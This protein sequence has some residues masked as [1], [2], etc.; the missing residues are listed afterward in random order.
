MTIQ[1]LFCAALDVPDVDRESF[2]AKSAGTN[3]RLA[4][5]VMD[6]LA[7]TDDGEDDSQFSAPPEVQAICRSLLEEFDRA[8]TIPARLGHY[9]IDRLL[10][11]GGMGEVY[12][13]HDEKLGRRVAIKRLAPFGQVEL[14]DRFRKEWAAV[15]Q[16]DSPYI[17]RGYA[18][19][20][21]AGADHL[22]MEY[23]DGEDLQQVVDEHG[24]MPP[25]TACECVHQAARGLAVAH[26]H[27][28]VHRDVKPA[29]LM[30]GL[31]GRVK[32]LDFGIAL[33]RTEGVDA[34]VRTEA[35]GTPDYAP[36]E[37][38]AG[39]RPLIGPE[40]DVYAL[41]CTLYFLLTGRP[42]FEDAIG[43]LH[44]ENAHRLA[45]PPSLPTRV[46]DW[47]PE[48]TRDLDLLIQ[49][50]LA[51]RP[52]D[53]LPSAD[54]V[55]RALERI[56]RSATKSAKSFYTRGGMAFLLVAAFVAPTLG[57]RIM[58]I[59]MSSPT[60]L[61]DWLGASAD[62]I[63]V[64]GFL[65]GVISLGLGVFQRRSGAVWPYFLVVIGF[66]LMFCVGWFARDRIDRTVLVE[67]LGEA[68][69]D[70]PYLSQAERYVAITN[71]LRAVPADVRADIR[72]ADLSHL[73]GDE[74]ARAI[75][76][77]EALAEGFRSAGHNVRFVAVQNAPSILRIDL[78]A[79]DTH[80]T[81]FWDR[82]VRSY[83][84]RLDRTRARD[85]ELAAAAAQAEHLVGD[86]IVV[87]Q[88]DWL[89][90][91]FA[92]L[93]AEK[94]DGLGLPNYAHRSLDIYANDYRNGSIDMQGVVRELGL[95]DGSTLKALLRR[96]SNVWLDT[97]RPVVTGGRV[98][99][100]AW[101]SPHGLVVSPYQ[102]LSGKLGLGDAI[103]SD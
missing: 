80:N 29:N 51:K 97:V 43:I 8:R 84:Y 37:M 103:V 63:E 35:L 60:G 64:I 44:K 76:E 81:A 65:G 33:V 7:E 55:D 100:R 73:V 72:Y 14:S 57:V 98:S 23:V 6:L 4:A 38:W 17:V 83:P 74:L 9:R 91:V 85:A 68:P 39:N 54:A 2:V 101:E 12:L 87:V 47:S 42:P 79:I 28:L 53:R 82:V 61:L 3:H 32:L 10:G 58:D 19:H 27:G 26:A 78:R 30:R 11:K 75:R 96:E 99:R 15:G 13:A 77:Y 21:D 46:G 50:L 89:L 18:I 95:A 45:S 90:T 24:A 70:T 25:D 67:P 31:D 40:A 16:L 86:R 5:E 1:E 62:V 71:D 94:S 48:K 56:T 36:P 88:G 20:T 66:G 69:V 22:V 34:R 59:N 102:H 41:G 92:D 93:L 52:E 49:Q